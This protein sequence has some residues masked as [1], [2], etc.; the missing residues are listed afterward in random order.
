MKKGILSGLKVLD[1]SRMLSGPYCTMMLADHGAEV[2]KIESPTGDTSRKTGPFKPEDLE[3]KWSG[4][5]V[6]LNRNKKSVVIDLKSK[7]GKKKFLSLVEK[8]DVLVENF[9]PGVMDK[10]GL[11]FNSLKKINNRL[12]YAAISGFGNPQFGK[13]P[14]LYWPSYDVVAQ[15]MGGIIGI[16]GPDKNTPTKVGPGVGDIFSG[17]MMSFGI[18]SALRMA[19]KTSKGQF[20]DLSMYDAVLSLCERI[21]YQY[22]FD[23]SIP[24]PEGNG[25]PLLVP[26]GIYKSK[27]GHIALGIVDNSFW[28][29]LTNII[30]NKELVDNRKY[31]TIESRQNNAKSLNLIVESWTITKTNKE[32]ESLLGGNVPFGPL[33]TA[34][35]IFKDSH[36]KK[37]SMIR[38]VK[39]PFD[40][41]IKPWRVAGNPLNFS[42]FPQPDFKSAPCLGENNKDNIFGHKSEIFKKSKSSKLRKAFGSF[43]TGVTLVTTRQE[44][45]TP[46]G[47]TANSF[48]SVSLDPPL[49]LVCISKNAQSYSTFRDSKYFA[50]N[51]LSESQRSTAGLFSS[52]SSEK[53]KITK[54]KKG[55]KEL[56]IIDSA[57][58]YFSCEKTNFQEAGD[59]AIII[60]SIKDFG[61][62]DGKPLGYFD[63]DYFS[64]GFEKSLIDMVNNDSNT[65]FGAILENKKRILFIADKNRNLTLPKSLNSQKN[66]EGLEDY[67]KSL[68]LKFKLDFLYSVYEDKEKN[69]HMI[70]YH[71]KFSGNGNITTVTFDINEIPY[72]KII[73]NAERTMMK[74]YHDEYHHG[75]FGIYQGNEKK[76]KVKK[77]F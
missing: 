22:D 32:L 25:H 43:A 5:F 71:G 75:Q 37:R 55:F 49:L 19:E 76:G 47:F 38:K 8:A 48:T 28:K 45:G 67:L 46:R 2:I 24:K 12:I 69:S 36:V 11:G 41:E 77:V 16:T 66:L 50:V 30:G 6:S 73:N 4:Y 1:L 35:E 72:E 33:N 23:N 51:V 27:D 52:Q 54:W 60:G 58:S 70:F 31:E 9:R 64:I 74:R 42:E 34:E 29:I 40:D 65:H 44:N 18:I 39:I 53:F 57:L 61:I 26:F 20:I 13:S 63:G 62:R 17:L 3:K 59:H 56:P 10:L 7:D 15:A 68:N 14:Y 21:I